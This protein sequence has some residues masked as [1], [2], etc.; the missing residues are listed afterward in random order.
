MIGA[1][2]LKSYTVKRD[3]N[4]EKTVKGKRVKDVWTDLSIRASIQPMSGQELQDEAV[5]GERVK[6]GIKIY[7]TDKLYAARAKKKFKADRICYND[8]LYEVQTVADWTS[9]S[10]CQKHYEYRAVNVNSRGDR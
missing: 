8:E 5:G 4:G 9:H 7:T 2:F 3:K 10:L 6:D 1:Q